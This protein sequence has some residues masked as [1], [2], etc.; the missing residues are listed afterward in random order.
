MTP[1][2]PSRTP[3]F[4]AALLP[5]TTAGDWQSTRNETRA[6]LYQGLSSVTSQQVFPTIS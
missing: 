6:P 4:E 5:A 3:V 2:K 1:T